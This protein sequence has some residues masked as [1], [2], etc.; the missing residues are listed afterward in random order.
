LLVLPLLTASL[1]AQMVPVTPPVNPP[2]TV[3]VRPVTPLPSSPT[4][5]LSKPTPTLTPTTPAPKVSPSAPV[6]AQPAVAQS[7]PAGV[8][9]GGRWASTCSGAAIAGNLL[10]ARCLN[11]QQQPIF[12]TLVLPCKSNNVENQD[13]R[14]VCRN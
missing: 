8:M 7:A 10:K 11:H 13:G 14:L 3:T 6:T 12:T 4:T 2:V 5:T 9:P 1:P